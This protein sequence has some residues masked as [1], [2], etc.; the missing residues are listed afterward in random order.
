MVSQDNVKWIYEAFQRSPHRSVHWAN[1]QLH[2][3][4]STIHDVLHRKLKLHAWKLQLVWKVTFKGNDSKKQF[5]L[6]ML[7]H[8]EKDETYFDELCYS[9]ET[10]HVHGTV[11]RHNCHVW[12]VKILMRLLNMSI[13]HWRS[14]CGVLWWK[15]KLSVLSFLK[16]LWWMV[17]LFWLWWRTLL[18]VMS[19]GNGFPVRWWTTSFLPSCLCLSVQGVSWLLDGKRGHTSPGPLIIHIWHLLILFFW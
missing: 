16:N 2:L 5:D 3:L 17:T 6:E 4:C 7:S 18:C 1:S 19:L 13:I 9:D 14:M 11:N 10:F 12:E 15:T 8:I